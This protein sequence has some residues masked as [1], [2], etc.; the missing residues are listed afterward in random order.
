[1]EDLVPTEDEIEWVVKRLRN[2]RSRGPSWMWAEHLKGWLVE[3]R[4]EEAAEAKAEATDVGASLL[5]GVGGGWRMEE[6]REKAAANM[7]NWEE[8]VALVRADFGEGMM[9]EEAMVQ[10]VV[11]IPKGKEGYC[12]I[13]LVEV[14]WKVV[15]EI[16]NRRLTDSITYHVFLHG[17]WA[18]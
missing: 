18:G 17:F 13:I 12:G 7:T 15:A 10:A 6:K 3:A 2:Q 11:L 9:A 8:V 16:L 14:M 1:M 4:K 5:G